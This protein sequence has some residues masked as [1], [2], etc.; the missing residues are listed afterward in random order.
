MGNLDR[1]LQKLRNEKTA[2]DNQV[3]LLNIQ[4]NLPFFFS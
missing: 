2:L 3:R 4:L 1:Y